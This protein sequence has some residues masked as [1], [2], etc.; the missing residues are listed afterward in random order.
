MAANK[1]GQAGRGKGIPFGL[2]RFSGSEKHGGDDPVIIG[3]A[4]AT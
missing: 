2:C 3:L 4:I 1:T